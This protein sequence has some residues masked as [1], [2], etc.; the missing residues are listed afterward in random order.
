LAGCRPSDDQ[1]REVNL[2]ILSSGRS[3]RDHRRELRKLQER[4]SNFSSFL[5]QS[6][7]WNRPLSPVCSGDW[8]LIDFAMMFALFGQ[9][10]AS[11]KYDLNR[12]KLGT[13]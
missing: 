12:R 9:P 8:H 6:I 2:S 4:R 7:V 13:M 1:Q 10:L 5:Y 11:S 3:K